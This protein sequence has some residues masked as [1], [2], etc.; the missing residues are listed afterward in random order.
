MAT[1]IPVQDAI[2][3]REEIGNTREPLR[4]LAQF[5]RAFNNRDLALMR[6]NWDESPDIVMDNPLGGVKRGWDQV[7]S[8]YERIFH[9]PATVQVEFYD[10]TLHVFGD[11]FFAVG[12]E[13][14]TF[15]RGDTSLPV[16]IR[17]TRVFRRTSDGRWR[18]IHHHGSFEDAA[19]LAA[20][21]Q[22]LTS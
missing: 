9:G 15:V 5:Y 3:G 13:R 16:A 4:A 19:L 7:R 1:I 20:Y 22:A 6:Q 17:T 11:V 8:V 18:Q 2:S 12:R 21:Q 14:G 10:Y